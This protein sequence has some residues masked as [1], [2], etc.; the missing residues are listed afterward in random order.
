MKKTITIGTRGSLL[1]LYQANKTQKILSEKFTEYTFKIKIIKTKGDKI[2][3]VALSKIGDKGL[4][5]KELEVELIAGT[6]DLAV[7]SLKDLPS[8]FPEGCK[9]GGL[10]ERAEVRDALVSKKGEKLAE[11]PKNAIIGTS[12]LRRKAQIL[13]YNPSFRIKDV[14]GNVDTRLQKL[15]NEDY[16]AL[17]MA[18][19]GLQ[20]LGFGE[21]ISELLSPEIMIPAAGQG[22]IA[23]E[24]RDNDEFMQEIINE[25]NDFETQK[26]ITAERAFLNAADGGC[27]VPVGCYSEINGD[28]ITLTAFVSSIDGTNEISEKLTCEISKSETEARALASRILNKG[29]KEILDEVRKMN[30]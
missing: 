9:L 5:T 15:Q 23:I 3:D 18:G 30:L 26:A 22:A 14:R 11:L 2:L 19:A 13:K 4:F 7:H 29:G 8:V 25:I 21:H 6:I 24:I 10:L 28:T 17:I 12:S 1:A 16:D 20:R 27:Q